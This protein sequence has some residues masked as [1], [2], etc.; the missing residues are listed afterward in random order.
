MGN[1]NTPIQHSPK[2][3]DQ[4]RERICVKHNSIRTET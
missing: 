1:I 3:L 2:L 4:I